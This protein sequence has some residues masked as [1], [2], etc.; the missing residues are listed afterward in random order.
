[1]A[2]CGIKNTIQY[3]NNGITFMNHARPYA[4]CIRLPTTKT[5]YAATNTP[6]TQIKTTNEIR[7]RRPFESQSPRFNAAIA[8]WLS[9]TA[10][11][12]AGAAKNSNM[13]NVSKESGPENT[14]KTIRSQNNLSCGR[15][16]D[17]NAFS[18]PIS[19]L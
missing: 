17:R 7:P 10:T 18:V 12:S 5:P 16:T 8:F 2:H 13:G 3:I 15:C 4:S 19:R 9:R 11:G 14:L 1:M 6:T